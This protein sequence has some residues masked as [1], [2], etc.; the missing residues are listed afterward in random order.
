MR[1]IRKQKARQLAE[2]EHVRRV[3]ELDE[4]ERRLNE[5]LA[6]KPR[7]TVGETN[8]TSAQGGAS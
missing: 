4:R 6:V 8:D 2:S 5:Q 3:A 1:E 7:E